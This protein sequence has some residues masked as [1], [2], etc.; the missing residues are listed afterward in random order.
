VLHRVFETTL[1]RGREE[2][3]VPLLE[4]AKQSL[5]REVRR[6]IDLHPTPSLEIQQRERRMLEEDVQS[7]LQLVEQRGANWEELELKF[8]FDDSRPATIQLLPEGAVRL[9][10]AIDRVDTADDQR[11][12]VVVDYK[13]G[14]AY[15]ADRGTGLY[16]GGRRLQNLLYVMAY[17]DL[18]SR[19]VERMEYQYP[20]RR[21]QNTVLEF[22]A[23]VLRA[24][25]F[26]L[27]RMVE[28]AAA[29]HFVPTDS[30]DDCT[31]CDFQAICRVRKDG[32]GVT[33][34]PADWSRR[35]LKRAEEEPNSLPTELRHLREV[36]REDAPGVV[37]PPLWSEGP[38]T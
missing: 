17:H 23:D 25:P 31:W 35:W 37:P 11:Q 30:A 5:D 27:G 20:T 14:S 34:P 13:T 24:G 4:H 12:A 1:R 3:E 22:E 28:G 2:P 8:G 18:Y 21:A 29:G 6:A 36:R 33:S 7:F 32:R 10:G 15:S 19:P 38:S 26:L 16:D 9:R